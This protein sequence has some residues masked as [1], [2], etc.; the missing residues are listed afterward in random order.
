M[1][2]GIIYL[3]LRDNYGSTE[4][5]VLHVNCINLWIDERCSVLSSMPEDNSNTDQ[6]K[7]KGH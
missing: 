4:T 5:V 2:L 1:Q 7:T 3:L 6:R